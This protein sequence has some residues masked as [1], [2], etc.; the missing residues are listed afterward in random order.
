[1]TIA[2]KINN[3]DRLVFTS[4]QHCFDDRILCWMKNH[5]RRCAKCAELR[6]IVR[7]CDVDFIKFK[8]ISHA[9]AQLI[10]SFAFDVILVT[11]TKKRLMQLR[12]MFSVK[13][14]QWNKS[15]RVVIFSS[16]FL[17]Q[18]VARSLLALCSLIARSH[19]VLR[20]R[21]TYQ[22]WLHQSAH[23][24]SHHTIYVRMMILKQSKR[25][26]TLFRRRKFDVLI[27]SI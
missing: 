2:E 21:Q 27:R 9:I 18:F 1:M 11:S 22:H 14:D 20:S 16:F 23:F 5:F 7:E 25:R 19:F 3:E 4:C 6:R 8:V 26:R 12:E 10:N 13:T 24:R 17:N 15:R